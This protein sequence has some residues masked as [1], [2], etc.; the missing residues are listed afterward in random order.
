MRQ[1][2]YEIESRHSGNGLDCSFEIRGVPD[3]LIAKYS[4]RSKQRDEAINRFITATGR[5]PT[6]NEVAVLVRETRA[7]KLIKISSDEVRA[8]A[9]GK[10]FAC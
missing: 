10:A 8:G 4:R 9:G 3:A 1:L 5:N 2:G 6:D 7:D